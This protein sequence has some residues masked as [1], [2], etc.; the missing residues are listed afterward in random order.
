[1]TSQNIFLFPDAHQWIGNLVISF[2]FLDVITGL[3]E[4]GAFWLY[5]GFALTGLLFVFFC[6]PETKG[7]AL[8]NIVKLLDPSAQSLPYNERDPLTGGQSQAGSAE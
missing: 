6:V 8:E 7:V 5:A 1:M 2:T 3:T 4:A